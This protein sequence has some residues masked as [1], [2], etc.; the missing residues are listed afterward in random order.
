MWND[1]F[2]F[3]ESVNHFG[4]VVFTLIAQIWAENAPGCTDFSLMFWK[5]S[6]CCFESTWGGVGW[7]VPGPHTAGL[8]CMSYLPLVQFFSF[9]SATKFTPVI[10]QKAQRRKTKL[11][12]PVLRNC[13]IM[14]LVMYCLND[15]VSVG[16]PCFFF[17]FFFAES[18]HSYHSDDSV[19]TQLFKCC[20]LGLGL[21][22]CGLGWLSLA[23]L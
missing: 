4:S 18:S 7:G 22:H 16:L 8:A 1:S 21:C 12:T 6:R 9:P 17:A 14:C 3:R 23:A 19:A 13:I 15:L 5:I 10:R 11:K 20:V 2:P